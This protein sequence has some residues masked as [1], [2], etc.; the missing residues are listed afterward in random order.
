[1]V[2]KYELKL[3]AG[4]LFI[5]EYKPCL[6][7]ILAGLDHPYPQY[8]TRAIINADLPADP[9]TIAV[10]P[11]DALDEDEDEEPEENRRDFTDESDENVDWEPRAHKVDQS[12][13]SD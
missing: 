12:Q 9:F 5:S 2:N 13:T 11:A 7:P 6:E 8:L 1:M 3:I 10:Q 4:N